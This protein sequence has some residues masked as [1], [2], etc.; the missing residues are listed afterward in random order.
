MYGAISRVMRLPV[1]AA[2]MISFFAFDDFFF[3]FTI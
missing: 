1:M 2:V 3:S